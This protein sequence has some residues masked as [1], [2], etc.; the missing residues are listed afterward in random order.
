MYVGRGTGR[1]TNDLHLSKKKKLKIYSICL[2]LCII[3]KLI[4]TY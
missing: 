1:I 4:N 2:Y 3:N